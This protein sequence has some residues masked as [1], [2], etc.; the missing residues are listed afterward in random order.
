M[1]HQ[2]KILQNKQQTSKKGE[3]KKSRSPTL[4]YLNVGMDYK[5]ALNERQYEAVTS[6][7]KYLRI[8]AGAGSGKTRVLTFR[9]AYLIERMGLFPSEILAITFTNKAAEEIKHRVQ[10][11]LNDYN[12]RLKIA[13]FHSFCARIL[14]E[15]IRVLDYPSTFTIL[16]E[17][18]Q[19]KLIKNIMDELEISNKSIQ[20]RSVLDY[21]ERQKNNWI[22]PKSAIANSYNNFFEECKAKIYEEYENQLK[23]KYYLDFNDLILKTIYIFENYDDVLAKWQSRLKHI[24][25]DEFQDVDNNQYILLKLLAGKRSAISVVGDPDQTIYSWRGAD[26]KI[27]LDFDKEFENVKTINLEQNYRSSGNILKVAN[28]LIRNNF[29]RLQKNLYTNAN[30]GE[31]IHFFHAESSQLEARYVA[32]NI[33]SLYDGKKTFYKDFAI[34][35]RANSLTA[36]LE[37]ALIERNIPYKIYGSIKFYQRKEIKDTLS[38]LKLALHFNDD[39][40]FDRCITS[41]RRGIGETTIEKLTSLAATEDLSILECILSHKDDLAIMASITPKAATALQYFASS[42]QKLHDNLILEPLKGDEILYDY[43]KDCGYID[44]LI[45]TEQDERIENIKE[46]IDQLKNYLKKE[47]A[48]LE[49]FLQEISLYTAQDEIDDK[50]QKTNSDYVKLMTIHTAKGL[51]FDNTFIY[52]LIDGI[53]PSSRAVQEKVDGLEE[54]RRIFYVALTRAKKRLFLTDSGGYSYMGAKYP[55]RFLQEIK[56]TVKKV[57]VNVTQDTSPSYPKTSIRKGTI[58]EHKTF[59]QGIVIGE[60]DG[61]IDVV[62][63]NP[64]F[65]RKTLIASHPFITIIK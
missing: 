21:I 39:I 51:E 57:N 41:H 35:Y 45:Q 59:G 11:M 31:E 49:E 42:I 3:R 15:E 24:L 23:K 47:N 27:I 36:E 52:G 26:I 17:E 6:S 65:G 5:N 25:V 19:K 14:R 48:S 55:S 61:L 33:I 58:I 38:Y 63:H 12:M 2:K 18:D 1:K 13:T 28:R 43:L 56:E 34:L 30:E 50:G 29:K 53:F 54:E 8:I 60:K 4:F 64:K 44:E 9:I 40:A 32:D 22:N 46:F 37:K 62:F 16:D 10:E 7:S 20:I